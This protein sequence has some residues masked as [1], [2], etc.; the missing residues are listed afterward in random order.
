MSWNQKSN[1][2]LLP[3]EQYPTQR[4]MLREFLLREF[5]PKCKSLSWIMQSQSSKFRMHYF[6]LNNSEFKVIP[7]IGNSLFDIII[8]FILKFIISFSIIRSK[9]CSAII[10]HDGPLEGII[11]IFYRSFFN[12]KMIYI[13]TAPL[14]EFESENNKIKNPLFNFHKFL[15]SFIFKRLYKIVID[16][17]DILH[18]ISDSMSSRFLGKA[19]ASKAF[20]L[21][22][23]ASSYF[24]SKYSPKKVDESKS[25]NLIYIG[26]LGKLRNLDFLIRSF[27]YAFKRDNSLSLHLIGWPEEPGDK[28]KLINLSKELEIQNSVFFK[29]RLSYNLLPIV[30]KD[31]LLGLS[32]IPPTSFFKISTPTKVLDYMSLGIPVLCNSEIYD[33]HF[34]VSKSGCGSSVKYDVNVFGKEILALSSNLDDLKKRGING[35]KWLLSN[36]TFTSQATNLVNFYKKNLN[37]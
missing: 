26:S 16:C 25:K 33:Q 6:H 36:R 12:L 15:K 19:N 23:S 37:I 17:A 8:N 9:K 28:E 2:L 29:D 20:C 30:I 27:S 14:W 4:S 31:S 22:E 18:P 10:V 13:I 34:L 35:R 3:K 1:F 5:S 11:G 21:P 7:K 32:P 24:L